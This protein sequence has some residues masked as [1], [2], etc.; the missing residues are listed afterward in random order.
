MNI[1]FLITDITLNGGIERVTVNLANL[2]SGRGHSVT[3]ISLF[4]ANST[5]FFNIDKNVQVLFV[6][7]ES[8]DIKKNRF[9]SILYASWKLK[10]YFKK[11]TI[12][13]DDVIVGQAFL[14]NIL[15]WIT[16]KRKRVFAC[17]HLK[18]GVYSPLIR[19][20]RN[21]IY[22]AF[23]QVIVLTDND[24][25]R[26][27]RHISLEKVSVIPN[28]VVAKTENSPNLNEKKIIAAGRLHYQKGFD[29]LI[30]AMKIVAKKHPDWTL[31]IFGEGELHESLEKDIE[32]SNLLNIVY[33]RGSSRNIYD[34][35]AHSSIF[36]L[37]SRYEG[38]VMVLLEAL[39]IGLPAVSFNCPEGPAEML[40]EGGGI[41]VEPENVEKLSEALNYMIEH[42]DFRVKCVE[43]K[44]RIRER[45]SPEKIYSLWM[46]IFQENL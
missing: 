25:E 9:S 38:F 17:E 15:L 23:S 46:N 42:K 8:Y 10:L 6:T 37:S 11:K 27:G 14:C 5:F 7:D 18:Y 19:M 40:S 44:D 20:F 26:F 3:I 32:M 33:L 4:H 34:E 16:A 30:R 43:I 28:M 36:V 1:N 31:N 22:S 39:A 2:F 12:S 41:L 29:L 21:V 35:Y 24:R 13:K 45:Y